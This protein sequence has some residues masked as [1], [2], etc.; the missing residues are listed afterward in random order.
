MKILVIGS[1]GREHALCWK[2]KQS[3]KVTHLYCAPG[4]GGISEIAQCVDI[5]ADDIVALADFVH[6]EKID[7]TVV[8]PEVP[9][10]AGIVDLFEEE[11]LRV[12]GPSK[13][14]ARL[15]GSKVFS[16]NFMKRWE[17][18]TAKYA[19]FSDMNAAL[20]YLA[21]VRC[22]VVVK[23]SGL[24]AG[25]GVIICH[26]R[27]QA[28]T[29]VRQIMG[30]R[31][32]KDAGTSL[33]VEE[34]LEG[35][36]VSVLAVCDGKDFL[37]LQSSQDHKRVFD[38]DKGPNTGGM[39]A[40]SPAPVATPGLLKTIAE[41]IIRPVVEGMAE[42]GSPF[43]GILY[44]GVMVTSEGPKVLEFNTR[45]GDPE[46]QAILPRLKTDLVDVLLASAEGRLGDVVLEWDDRA[47]VCVVMASGGYPGEYAAGREIEGLLDVPA[48]TI[49]FH[50]GTRRDGEKV[51]TSGGR[52]LGV[53]ALGEGI[54]L[55]IEKAYAGVARISFD[56][57][58]WR[59]DIGKRA[60]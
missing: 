17:I 59:K 7:L 15:E 26:D 9:L 1:G 45:F 18:P 27:Q 20:S 53:T 55:A 31:I 51:L 36:E 40:Y 11:G 32:F 13:A 49:V 60:L 29:A 8:G 6:Q 42:E 19:S 21:E 4:N 12:F 25:K 39:G 23:A 50:A 41:T 33:V 16:K 28:E 5:K 52:V 43:K 14:A 38:D 44:A 54:A 22:P 56:G 34:F 48:E 30:E 57:A 2:I 47:C 24:A 37:L 46:A 35:E 10:V 58:H 3:S